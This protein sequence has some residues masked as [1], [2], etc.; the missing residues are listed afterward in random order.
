MAAAFHRK[1]P[2]LAARFVALPRADVPDDVAQNDMSPPFM[3][4]YERCPRGELHRLR[5]LQGNKDVGE[6]I[7]LIRTRTA[8]R[9]A[10][11]VSLDIRADDRDAPESWAGALIAIERYLRDKGVAYV[12]VLATFAPL[13]RALATLGFCRLR[14]TPMWMRDAARRLTGAGRWHLMAIEGDL[15]YL[16]D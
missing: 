2:D 14:S 13:R 5:C 11:I 10:N 15:G 12:N 4:W 1:A 7:V 6:A 3:E 9:H 16:L 8:G